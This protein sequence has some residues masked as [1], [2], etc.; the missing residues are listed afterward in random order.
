[1]VRLFAARVEPPHERSLDVLKGLAWCASLVERPALRRVLADAV[2]SCL[3]NAQFL[4]H[5][6]PDEMYDYTTIGP[7]APRLANAIIWALSQMNSLDAVAQLSRVRLRIRHGGAIKS[8]ERALGEI[9]K[10]LNV[11]PDDLEELA[12]PDFG[13]EN[14]VLRRTFGEWTAEVDFAGRKGVWTWSAEGKKAPKS[15]PASIKS[16][17]AAELKE[18]KGQVAEIEKLPPAHKERLD[19]LLREEKTWSLA[20]WRERYLD[21]PFLSLLARRIIWEWSTT[22]ENG[23]AFLPH[24]EGWLNERGEAVLHPP[25]DATIRLWHPNR[26]DA[27]TVQSWRRLLEDKGIQQPFKQAHREIYPLTEAERQTR[28][29]SNRFAAHIIRQHQFNALCATRGWK[30]KLRLM[31]DDVAPPATKEMPRYN[32]RA[33]FWIDGIGDEYAADTNETGTFLRLATDQVRFY[34]MEAPQNFAHVSGGGY[35]ANWRTAPAEPLPLEEIP[36]LIFSEIMRDVDLFVGVASVGNDPTWNDGGPD[37]RFINYWQDY[38]FG[39]LSA[40]AQTRRDLLERLVPRLK[41]AGRCALDGKNLIVRGDLRTYKIHLGSGNILMEPNDEY[42][43]IVPDRS[44]QSGGDR[45]F[46]PFEGDQVLSIILSKA[47]MLSEDKQITDP[48]IVR[49]IKS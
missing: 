2:P 27:A 5:H 6:D 11:A 35:A 31:V 49:Q 43:C 8:V 10:R 15:V 25:E 20:I 1:Y 40:T 17:F 45:V 4:H 41:I 23:Q 14:G 37:G 32:L 24:G 46:L 13:L 12:V 44:A 7:R 18:M 28:T 19:L 30:N 38:S 9:A 34:R 21:H 39:E 22:N 16:D 26:H 48:T 33:E 42:L 29:Y 3:K 47:F 36:P